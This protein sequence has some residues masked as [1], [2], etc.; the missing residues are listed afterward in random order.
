M[1]AKI[2][3]TGLAWLT[4]MTTAL[5]AGPIAHAAPAAPNTAPADTSTV[6]ALGRGMALRNTSS[7]TGLRLEPAAA[8]PAGLFKVAFV[9]PHG[10]DSA[11]AS[12]PRGDILRLQAESECIAVDVRGICQQEDNDEARPQSGP[13]AQPSTRAAAT[14]GAALV[15]LMTLW[16]RLPLR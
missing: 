14:N 15:A 2:T 9:E 7:A 4:A 13:A 1:D 6:P 11:G 12:P 5:A 8:S 10:K 16:L 3:K